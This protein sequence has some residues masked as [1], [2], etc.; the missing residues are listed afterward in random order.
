M[1][2]Y[3][4]INTKL[5]KESFEIVRNIELICFINP[6]LLKKYNSFLKNKLISVKEKKLYTYVNNTW[7]KKDYKLF[8][9]YKLIEENNFILEHLFL[10]NNIAENLHGKLNDY[11]PKK[12]LSN[13]NFIYAITNIIMNGEIKNSNHFRVLSYFLIYIWYSPYSIPIIHSL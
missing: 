10:T 4:I 13:Y 5:T 6:K 11:I 9:Y 1:K 12:K 2:Q 3:K 7:L 8:N